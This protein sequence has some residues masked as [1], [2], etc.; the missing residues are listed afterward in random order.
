MALQEDV[1]NALKELRKENV[2]KFDQSVDL[3]INL[4]KFDIKRS[5]VNLFA[6]VPN[7]IKEKK[8]A[9]FL[10][11]QSDLIDT[12][13]KEDFKKYND[14]KVL[15]KLVEKYD[16]FIAQASVMPKVATTFGRVLGPTG[17][18]P[19]P[20]LGIILNPDE[21]TINELKEKIN[22]SVKIRAKESSI[23]LAI[24]KQS[25]KDEAIVENVMSIFNAVLKELPRNM[26]N[27]KNVELKFTMTKPIKIKVR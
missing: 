26:E 19:S 25:M 27:V 2:R 10:E 9:A 22:S 15:K 20:Q 13:T 7:Q 17:K 5:A 1:T 23:K 4:Q 16:F 14:K 8:I 18:M 24:G 3:I 12:I 11:G 6:F 21:K